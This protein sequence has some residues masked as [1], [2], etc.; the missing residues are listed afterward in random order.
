MIRTF[1]AK[2][3]KKILFFSLLPATVL[4][5]YFFWVKLPLA[6]LCCMVFL[7]FVVE[8]LIHTYYVFTDEGCLFIHQGR[9]S[10]VSRHSLSDIEKVDIVSPS[11]LSFLKNKDTVMLTFCDGS[12]KFITPFP[13]EEFCR[14]F[15]R[16][17][18]D[19]LEKT[20]GL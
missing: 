1:H 11:S 12:I 16:K 17:Q 3:N 9:F 18:E 14:Y 4:A 19:F 8:R 15:K 20:D 7:V 2:I 10:K 13:A 5:I 6:A